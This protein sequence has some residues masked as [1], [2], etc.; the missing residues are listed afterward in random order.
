M[1]A[2]T[3]AV[4][5]WEVRE[6]RVDPGTC[7]VAEAVFALANGYVGIR[8]TL[9]EV[10]P[11]VERG[12]FLSGVFETHPLAYPEG[13]YGHP[14]EG[15]SIVAVP[16]GTQLRLLV[17][18]VP[19]DVRDVH[20]EVHERSLDLRAGT[21]DRFL[22][23][24][25]PS[26]T[27][28]EMRSRRLVSLAEPS[29]CAI[30][31]EVRAVDGPAHLVLRS[32]LAVGARPPE[33]HSDDPRVAEALD[34]PFTVL[35]THASATG[36]TLA[37]RTRRTAVDVAACVE[38]DVEGA[39]SVESETGTDRVVTTVVATLAAGEA[40]ALT[41]TLGYAWSR[42][43]A[44]DSMV[45]RAAAAVRSGRDGGWE[46]LTAEQRRVLDE[47]WARADVEIDGDGEVQQALRYDVFQL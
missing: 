20:P 12:T 39:E 35:A 17:D 13:G 45:E 6:P 38:H 47:L 32:E 21:L 40:L 16:D 43:A 8:G 15:Q 5:P 34:D 41:K 36:G 27:T 18:G 22:R 24:R 2:P 37:M 29:V 33:V 46:R 30:R 14:E 7:G 28:L 19:L 11:C 23:W 25:A 44:P 42:G 4:A 9:D 3:L 10:D 31:Y 1:S 26:G